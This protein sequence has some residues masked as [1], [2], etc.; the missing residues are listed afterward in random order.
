V[1][2][3][4]RKLVREGSWMKTK[5]RR[6]CHKRQERERERRRKPLA[7]LIPCKILRERERERD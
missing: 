4:E 5:G 1:V 6:R 3:L 7:N 2:E